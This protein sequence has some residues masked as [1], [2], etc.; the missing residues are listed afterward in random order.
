MVVFGS[1]GLHGSRLLYVGREFLGIDIS[2]Y[3]F[4]CVRCV[5]MR[6]RSLITR[7]GQITLENSNSTCLYAF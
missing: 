4:I 1:R 3:E 2:C 6:A 7:A 5:A